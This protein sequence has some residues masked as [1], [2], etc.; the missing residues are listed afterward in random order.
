M[1]RGEVMPDMLVG[2]RDVGWSACS[3]GTVDGLILHHFE[4]MGSLCL[5]VFTGESS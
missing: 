4:T 2:Q 5:L 3:I 1:L